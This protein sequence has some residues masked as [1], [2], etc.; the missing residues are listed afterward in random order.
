M[1]IRNPTAPRL[2]ALALSLAT[3]PSLLQAASPAAVEAPHG[4]VVSSQHLASEAGA[5]I[6]AAG[7]NAVD[8]AVAVGY[9][10][11]VT[12]PCCGNI[13]GGGFMVIRLQKTGQE[14]FVNFREKAPRAASRDMFLDPEGR[15]VARASLDGYRAVTVPG[16]VAGLESALARY[17]SLPRA[18]VL[19]PAIKLARDGFVLTR[20]D[21]D[22]ID[23]GAARLHRDPEAARVFFHADGSPLVPGDTLRQ[24][25]LARTLEAIARGGADAFYKG[26]TAERLDAAMRANGGLVTRQ[27][28][29][30]YTST[31]G[32]PLSCDYRGYR[33]VSAP[34]PSSGG[35]TLCETLQILSG[36]DLKSLGF[37]SAA[38]IHYTVEALRHAF[39]DRNMYLGDPAFVDNPVQR[40]LSPAYAAAI[41][42]HIDPQ[43]ATPSQGVQP[44][45]APHESTQTTHYSVVDAAGNAV[46][47]TYTINGL[48]GAGVMAPGTGF[49]L[50]N[51]MDDFTIKPGVPNM[52][53][54]VQD[55][56]NLIQPGKR[57]LSSMTPTLV[58]KDGRVVLVVGSPGGSRIIT[59]V[60]Q[61]LSNVIDHGMSPQEAVDAPRIHHQ[62]L[63]D[64]IF[65]EPYALSPDTRHL[66]EAAGYRI[67]DQGSW[68]AAELIEIPLPASTAGGPAS[69]GNDAA[70][71]S[72]RP[73]LVYGAH[74]DRRPAG[75]AAGY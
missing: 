62:W 73:G 36:Y 31:E 70:L 41:R 69:A 66:L 43:R 13:G 17:G 9:A 74:D 59:I 2:F 60:L 32:A 3:L 21:T 53:G 49:M 8:A 20:G 7:G 29:A 67:I 11:A 56:A 63:P 64:A 35:V 48:F 23:A 61:V 72:L 33:I 24:P 54:L 28:L 5:A 47:V 46:S 55:R 10:E 4:M 52:F 1:V 71:G 51:E 58:T 27:D 57:P 22:I 15:P 16:T 19:A 44:G 40:L 37:H 39:M 26:E 50:N 25:A 68:G 18:K 42:E 75:L 14:I 30:E 65:A 12:N 45:I 6:L 34:P 38:S